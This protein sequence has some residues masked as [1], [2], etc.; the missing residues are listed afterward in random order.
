M[1]HLDRSYRRRRSSSVAHTTFSPTP[2]FHAIGFVT[3]LCSIAHQ[4][5]R[6]GSSGHEAKGDPGYP[7]LLTQAPSGGWR[8]A[9]ISHDIRFLRIQHCAFQACDSPQF[10]QTSTE[11]D[12]YLMASRQLASAA[13]IVFE[14]AILAVTTQIRSSVV[15]GP[16]TLDTRFRYFSPCLKVGWR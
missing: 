11:A 15:F 14:V 1:I 7:D 12:V 8:A 5:L 2:S 13:N 4:A 10:L 16:K 9:N 3:L 6:D